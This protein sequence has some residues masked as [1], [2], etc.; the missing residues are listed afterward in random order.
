[1]NIN[2]VIADRATLDP[3]IKI[4]ALK[5]IGPIWGGWQTFRQFSTDN[6][7]CY[8]S[9]KARDL[10]D[11]GFNLMCNFYVSVATYPIDVPKN[12]KL[13]GGQFEHEVN[14]KDEI[15]ALHLCDATADIGLLLGFDLSSAGLDA[16]GVHYK[17]LVLEIISKSSNQWVLID[18]TQELDS[19]FA[20]LDNITRDT[21][22]NV[23]K[24]A[25]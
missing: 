21:L 23:I 10:V 19:S 18:H 4:E 1:M 7:V 2:W 9:D 8:D 3:T 12:T 14:N 6:A 25:G 5:N 15:V 11:K 24:L 17:G 16:L 20:E 22:A 13:F